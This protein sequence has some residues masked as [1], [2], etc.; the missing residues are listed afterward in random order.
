MRTFTNLEPQRKVE[1]TM[2]SGS[3]CA[4]SVYDFAHGDLLNMDIHRVKFLDVKP[5]EITSVAFNGSADTPTLAVARSDSSIEIWRHTGEG[6]S[7]CHGVT[8]P[9]SDDSSIQ[10]VLWHGDRLFSAGLAGMR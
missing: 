5:K 10:T 6:R 4:C 8:I 3:Y 2:C 1:K 9:G 7:F